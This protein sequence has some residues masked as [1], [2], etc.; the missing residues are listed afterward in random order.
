MSREGDLSAMLLPEPDTLKQAGVLKRR[1][2]RLPRSPNY[3]VRVPVSWLLQQHRP[4]PFDPQSRLFLLLL[5][6]S[7][8]GQ[9]DVKVT[10]ALAAELG[11]SARRKSRCLR[12][13]EKDGWIR[14]D[15][16]GRRAPMVRP[17]VIAY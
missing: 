7:H 15:R 12:Q 8:W 4:H 14:V 10:N 9:R 1:A 6:R 16:A 2:Q 3:F 5:F 17:I 13:L 11:M